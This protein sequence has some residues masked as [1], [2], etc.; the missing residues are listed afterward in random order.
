M[1]HDEH[2]GETDVDALFAIAEA[3]NRVGDMLEAIR[4]T[5]SDF[6]ADEE[7]EPEPEP[8]KLGVV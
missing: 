7:E 5:L 6:I 2:E 4:D 3:V 1:S 8:P